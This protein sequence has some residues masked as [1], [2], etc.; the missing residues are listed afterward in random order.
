MSKFIDLTGNRYNRL[1]VI[2]RAENAKGGVPVWKCLCDC[3]NIVLV[4]GN[5][6]KSGAVQSCGCLI[7]EPA[8]N[9]THGLSKDP[10]YQR[11]NQMKERCYNPSCKSY[12]DYGGRGIKMCDEWK[13]SV[14]S[15]AEWAFA[16]GY[17]REL[18]IERID[19]DGDYC[20]SNC[21]WIKRSEQPR[22]RRLCYSITYNGKTKN[23]SDWC[24]ELGL[25]YKRIHNR[26]HKLGWSF[27]RA[28]SEPVHID[29]QKGKGD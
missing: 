23:L 19:N 9:R 27:E 17:K 25:E 11:W 26:M 7:H 6:L 20:P 14:V 18:T 8:H 12:A 16:N 28:I 5:N 21:K 3:G 13:D 24:K 15:F 29:K 4:R 1:M 22:N 10:I 2:E